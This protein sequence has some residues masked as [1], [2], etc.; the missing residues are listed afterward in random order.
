VTALAASKRKVLI[1]A[2][3]ALSLCFGNSL[4][5][6]QSGTQPRSQA[7]PAQGSPGQ[8]RPLPTRVRVSEGVTAALLIKKVPPEYPQEAHRK[9]VQ[10]TVYLHVIISKEG[11]VAEV[12]V[13]SGDP[14]LTDAAIE[15]ARQ[16]KYKPYLLNGH[17]V[18]VET[19]L[20]LNFVLSGN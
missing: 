3:C 13:V 2:A 7:E 11:D 20:R 18:E 5:A 8:E 6:G 12:S 9:R 19:Q 16:W 14:M 15:A 1:V 4:Y 17:P 10:G